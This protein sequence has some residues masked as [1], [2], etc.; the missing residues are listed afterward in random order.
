M[1]LKEY[2]LPKNT[3]IG[4]WYFPHSICD[5]LIEVFK[6][7]DLDQNNKN[8]ILNNRFSNNKILRFY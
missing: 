1:D 6:K 8:M 5:G 2:I 3:F 4:G 7:K